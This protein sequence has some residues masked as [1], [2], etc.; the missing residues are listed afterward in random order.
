MVLYM[1]YDRR[2]KQETGE[3]KGEEDFLFDGNRRYFSYQGLH[4][5]QSSELTSEADSFQ[6]QTIKDTPSQGGHKKYWRTVVYGKLP[7]FYPL[8][9]NRLRPS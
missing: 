5:S 2:G 7:H 9:V 1:I 4:W 6:T 8:I 3:E